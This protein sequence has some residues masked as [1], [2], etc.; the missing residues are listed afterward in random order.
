MI[1]VV[2]ISS[3]MPLV[4][5]ITTGRGMNFT[6]C[7]R[8]VIARTT[9]ITPAIIVTISSPDSPWSAMMPATMT[10]NAPVGPPTWMLEPPSSD[11]RKP[12]TMAV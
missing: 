7:P 3:A 10:T 2:A 11:T 4:N 12:P 8:P 6:A 1:C 5:P 9:S